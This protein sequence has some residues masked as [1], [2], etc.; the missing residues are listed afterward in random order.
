MST[1]TTPSS[2]LCLRCSQRCGRALTSCL[3]CSDDDD[4]LASGLGA[5]NTSLPAFGRSGKSFTGAVPLTADAQAPAGHDQ[6]QI[7]ESA[8]PRN[9]LDDDDELLQ[10]KA[11]IAARQAKEQRVQDARGTVQQVWKSVK[12]RA[13][14]GPRIY[15]GERVVHLN[16]PTLNAPQKWP[17][18]SVST[19]KYNIVTFIPKFLIGACRPLAFPPERSTRLTAFDW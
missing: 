3:L 13:M 14:G 17:G 15:E 7:G 18:N 5:S 16:N 10:A 11:R 2:A 9:M 8:P 6:G 12:R 19:S 1:S 4:D